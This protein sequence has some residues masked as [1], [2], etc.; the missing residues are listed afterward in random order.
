MPRR[1]VSTAIGLE[2]AQRDSLNEVDGSIMDKALLCTCEDVTLDDLEAS[3]KRG[4]TDVESVKRYTGFGTGTCQ[5]KSCLATAARLIQQRFGVPQS[6]FTPRPPLRPLTLAAAAS[7][8]P[9][10]GGHTSAIAYHDLGIPPADS[11]PPIK[12]KADV[13]IIGGG[14]QGLALAHYLARRKVNDVVVL[15]QAYLNAG[16]SGRNGGGIRMQ[17]STPTNIELAKRSIE[18]CKHFARELGVNIWLRQG[19]YL[20]LATTA[21]DARRLEKNAELHRQHGVPTHLLTPSEAKG[22]VPE[23]EVSRIVAAA[24]NREDGVLFPWPFLWGYASGVEKMGVSVETFTRVTG[25]EIEGG[26]VRA[27]LTSRGRVVCQ[28]AVI[29]A[30]AW[31]PEVAAM[32]GVKLPNEPK[33]HEICVTEPLKPFL[34]P[35]V[36]VLGNGLYFSQSMRGEVIGGMGDPQDRPG[37]DMSSSFRFLS[38]Y[39]RAVLDVMPP[40]G[41]VKFVRQWAGCYDVTPDNAPILGETPGIPN[42]LQVNGFVGHGFMMA[43]AVAERM[44]AWMCGEKD[45]LFVRFNLSRFAEGRMEREDFIIG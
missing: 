27:V 44:A 3:F 36:S 10:S 39:A 33:R 21:D 7:V 34:T 18:I 22:V 24:Y 25:F 29:A 2:L 30:G 43:P 37:L 31:S 14:I 40:L 28:R 5:G 15:E 38:R 23:L 35:L 4:Y 1:H 16:A 32:A 26:R 11:R 20:F 45:E 17:W 12:S 9:D 42:L 41:Q 6:P 8:D 13:V 19:G